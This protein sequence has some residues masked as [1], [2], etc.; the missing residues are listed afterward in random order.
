MAQTRWATPEVDAFVDT[1]RS[2]PPD[3]VASAA[4]WTA[5]DVLAH[6]VA[7]GA[8]IARLVGNHLEGGPASATIGFAEREPAFRSLRYETLIDLVADNGIFDLLAAMDEADE[9]SMIDFTGWAVDADTLALHI[10]SELALHRWDLCG[11]D[12]VSL[13]LLGQPELTEHAVRALNGF[14]MI[15]ERCEVRGQRLARSG[16][17]PLE[18]RLR[19]EGQRDVVLSPST[20]GSTSLALAEPLGAAGITT[21]AAS[22]LL[23][24]WGRR[25]LGHL[26][27]TTLDGPELRALDLWLYK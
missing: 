10:R 16:L 14:D 23:M 25:P 15:A 12:E 24:L 18:V 7:G 4:G 17:G 2:A 11:S 3:L 5:H 6:A 20:A 27:T 21:D 9:D 1:A 22:R 26:A 19:V 13:A 8:E